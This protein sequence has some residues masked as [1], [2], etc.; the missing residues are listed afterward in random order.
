MLLRL[1]EWH[2]KIIEKVSKSRNAP[3]GS[4]QANSFKNDVEVFTGFRPAIES[5]YLT[6]EFY[7]IDGVTFSEAS[8]AYRCPFMCFRHSDGHSRSGETGVI[9]SSH[10]ILNNT[11]G[12]HHLLHSSATVV[13]SAPMI[14]KRPRSVDFGVERNAA[15][16]VSSSSSSSTTATSSSRG[17]PTIATCMAGPSGS[18]G[19]SSGGK[20]SGKSRKQK[21]DAPPSDSL[22]SEVMS[23]MMG[24]KSISG[25][26][27]G[28]K[29][30][31]KASTS[32]VA[33][34]VRHNNTPSSSS[35]DDE[36][37]GPSAHGVVTPAGAARD[38]NRSS[39]SSEGF[40]DELETERGVLGVHNNIGE[41][42]EGVETDPLIKMN[43]SSSAATSV[44]GVS[45]NNANHTATSDEL[46]GDVE[47]ELDDSDSSLSARVPSV[48]PRVVDAVGTIA[49]VAGPSGAIGSSSSSVEQGK[50]DSS[51][52]QQ[53]GDE[54]QMYYFDSKASMV[55]SV[56]S[57][58]ESS[59]SSEEGQRKD[60]QGFNVFCNLRKMEDDWE[61]LFAR[62]E[63]L[64]A[65]GHSKEACKLG[66]KLA[67]ELLA[68][69]PNLTMDVPP[70]S[71]G[72]GKKKKIN[73]VAHQISC[74]ASAT[75]AKCGFLCTVLAESSD[76]FY[77][78][79]QVG[80]FGLELARP[81]ASTKPLEVKLANQEAELAQLLKRIP[82][83]QKELNM[84]R[85]KAENLR[86]G[87][88]KSRGEALL[89]L[90]LSNFI[91]EALVMPTNREG[92]CTL[93]SGVY[94][95][96]SDETLGSEAAVSALGLK[97]NVSEADH[98]LLCEGTRRQ[99]GDLALAMLLHYK[100]DS[101]KL[102]KVM[103]K[104][105]D[106]EIHQL[107]KAPLPSAYYSNSPP[108][109]SLLR[110]V[111]SVLEIETSKE[112]LK[113]ASSNN[114]NNNNELELAS[115]ANSSGTSGSSP[116]V[117]NGASSSSSGG[118]SETTDS[119]A[120]ATLGSNSGPNAAPA[121]PP[122]VSVAVATT[123]L[124]TS[125]TQPGG[126][127]STQ[128][129]LNSVVTTTNTVNNGNV[130]S[131][132][133]TSSHN[134][135]TPVT[136]SSGRKDGRYKGKRAYPVLPNQP[137]EAGAHFMFELAKIVLSKAGGSSNQSLF[138][139]P[140]NGQN[141]R[142]PHR[143]LHM[144]AFHIELYAIGLH[145]AVSPNWLSRTYS[146]HVS[147]ITGEKCFSGFRVFLCSY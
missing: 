142:G 8:F 51:E 113:M 76:Y 131:S 125:P 83:G 57:P 28:L 80:M 98:P 35:F 19:K 127:S 14:S 5:C 71:G 48:L 33:A 94:H 54:Y 31:D 77:L 100:D 120:M 6:W 145:N 36:L 17:G 16:H 22:V 3:V 139:Q 26:A 118:E 10:A 55:K 90:V 41:P 135:S 32:S 137:S 85:V 24:A 99:R 52:S 34:A 114:N 121:S 37:P 103:D 138:T 13:S 43:S 2:V 97:A 81:P 27:S 122:T 134:A 74:L 12:E 30:K 67:Q 9:H 144:C 50:F 42:D 66:V 64:H 86:D 104:L 119:S 38:G 56:R 102:S 18:G 68:N 91:F 147:W 130:T 123:N 47:P 93:Q 109:T 46:D 92:R 40:C 63:G 107:S 15:G 88:F 110:N 11:T 136:S 25:S 73:P 65:H 126:S 29:I 112:P 140:S 141:P 115:S 95:L 69:P 78:A 106:R 70:T 20:S 87:N 49:A 4:K 79:F 82:I 7:P 84:I 96:P 59:S 89:P 133:V 111:S 44:S 101:E 129:P 39:V 45:L 62:A 143:A 58:G 108:T 116:I 132:G 23:E 53:S 21:K 72:K 75:L 146:S 61:I 117:A 105:L 1:Q 124:Q 60:S 128:S